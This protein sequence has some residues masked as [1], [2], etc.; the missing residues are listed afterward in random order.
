M[1]LGLAL[2]PAALSAD[3]DSAAII[4]RSV[5]AN[6]RNY[7][8]LPQL[9]YFRVVHQPSGGTR[10]YQEIMLLG[11][12]YSILTEIDG[13][14]LSP[15]RSREEQRRLDQVR[16]A[17]EAESH[18]QRQKRVSAYERER[19]RDQFLLKEMVNAL[20]F[21]STGEQRLGLYD[22]YVFRAE[23]RRG[24]RPPNSRARVLTAMRGTL[25]IEKDT[26]QWVRAEAEVYRPVSIEGFLA[27]V[28]PGTRFRLDQAP[29]SESLW[30]PAHFSM[31][32]RARILFL[33]PRNSEE[34]ENYY[35]YAPSEQSD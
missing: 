6:Q 9:N 17:R 35:G 26:Y 22:T 23:P 25:W 18:E 3:V 2:W 32:E 5:Q 27:Q 1:F 21:R 30:E 7:S 12:R 19:Q 15:D 10:T 24:Y 33:F 4:Q 13:K 34:D 31:K 28:Q 16:Q 8:A 29:I 11:S 20:E 14:Q